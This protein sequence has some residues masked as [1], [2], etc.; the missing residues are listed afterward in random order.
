MLGDLLGVGR[1]DD[2]RRHAAGSDSQHSARAKMALG[3]GDNG[4]TNRHPG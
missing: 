2:E 4:A 1:D 3:V